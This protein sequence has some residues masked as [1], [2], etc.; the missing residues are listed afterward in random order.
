MLIDGTGVPTRNRA[1]HEGGFS[2]KRCRAELGI[3]VAADT[4]GSLPGDIRTS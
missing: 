4:D 1:G 3:Q 2:G